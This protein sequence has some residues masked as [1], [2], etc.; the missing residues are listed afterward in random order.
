[1]IEHPRAEELLEAVARWID[2]LRPALAARDA[3]LARVAVNALQTVRRELVQGPAAEAA[4]V[5]R[6]SALLGITGDYDTLNAELCA[7]LRAGALDVDAP[8]LLPALR[9]TV[10]AQIAIDQPKYTPDGAART[11]QAAIAKPA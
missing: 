6:F 7:R 2:D 1:M 10:A 5:E 3:F 11:L 9:A 4:A 8:G